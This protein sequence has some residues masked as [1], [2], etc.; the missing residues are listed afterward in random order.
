[1]KVKVFDEDHEKDLEDSINSF[2]KENKFELS[3]NILDKISNLKKRYS[4]NEYYNNLFKARKYYKL[5]IYSRAICDK[6][7]KLDTSLLN[8]T[9][10]KSAIIDVYKYMSDNVKNYEF[11]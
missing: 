6:K 11:T 8:N 2:I 10:Y 9:E 1:M 3:N 5:L 4:Y 7:F